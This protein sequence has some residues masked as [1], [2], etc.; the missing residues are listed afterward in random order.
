LTKWL[1][2]RTVVQGAGTQDGRQEKRDDKDLVSQDIEICTV[3]WSYDLGWE[4]ERD[5]K[6]EQDG[7]AE[8]KKMKIGSS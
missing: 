8:I 6:R 2:H 7:I 3:E 1:C 5:W 4:M